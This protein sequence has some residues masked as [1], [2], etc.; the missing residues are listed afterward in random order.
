MKTNIEI[1]EPGTKYHI[2]NRGINREDIFKINYDYSNFLLGLNKYLHIYGKIH[3]Y[4]LMPNHFHLLFETNSEEEIREKLLLPTPVINKATGEAIFSKHADKSIS[5]IISNAFSSLFKSHAQR[6]NNRGDRVG[7]LFDVP[8]RR[9]VIRD[10]QYFTKLIY[11]IHKNPQVH[12]LVSDF[13]QYPFSSYLDYKRM[14]VGIIFPD[15]VLNWFG[16]LDAFIKC[17]GQDHFYNE[18]QEYLLE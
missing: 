5:W 9:K 14:S 2:Y 18:I 3:T 16:S 17:H 7:K 6:I 13:R 8:F 10:D 1:L 12:G 11:Y 4:C 15:E